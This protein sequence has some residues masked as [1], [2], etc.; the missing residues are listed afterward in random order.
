MPWGICFQK[1]SDMPIDIENDDLETALKKLKARENSFRLLEKLNKLGS[2]E[3]D[4]ITKKSIWSENSYR[5]YDKEP[6]SFEPTLDTFFHHLIPEDRERAKQQLQEILA[7]DEPSTFQGKC[8]LDSQREIDIRVNTQALYDENGQPVKLIGTTQD[9]TEKVKN[10]KLLHEHSKLLKHQ[11]HHDELTQL[12]NRVLFKDRLQQSVLSHKRC[13]NKFA[14]LFIDL[15]HFKDINDSLGHHIGDEVL[16]E[17]SQRLQKSIRENDTLA[18]LGGDEFTIILSNIDS[19]QSA[20]KIAKKIVTIMRKPFAVSELKLH[21]TASIGIAIYPDDSTDENN[22][23]KYADAAMYTSK[24]KGR[25]T[26]TVYKKNMTLSVYKRVILE[27]S[28]RIAIKEED[29]IVYFQAQYLGKSDTLIGSEALIRW[30]H[31]ELD[32]IPPNE[33][34]PLAEDLNLIVNI[35]RIVMKK[36]IK[37]YAQW[38]KMGLNP[39]KLS[40]NLSMKQLNEADFINYLLKIIKK[41]DFDKNLLELEV[42]ETQVMQNPEL[43]IKKLQLISNLGIDIVMDDFGTGYSSLSYLKKLPLK[44]LKI[45]KSFI[46]DIPHD[47]DDMTI[48]KTIIAMG[49]GFNLKLIAEGV[50]TNEQKEFVLESGC[51]AIQ[52]YLYAKPLSAQD[53]E[54][55][56]KK[57]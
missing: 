22:L 12:P 45:D 39:G 51:E 57:L 15:D 3:V 43:S 20:K 42:T 21:M 50:E 26:Y 35:D 37:Q 25:N 38:Y 30:Q 44:K 11:A 28:L 16:K 7:T 31:S 24:E 41:Y 46:Q 27:N 29:F 8:K 56:L 1:K 13:K 14:L 19:I 32:L 23:I 53:M 40:L 55:L 9:I 36:A 54:K 18:R 17:A 48:T 33:F 49:K 2:W 10:D 5:I 6:S 34:I 52:G 47:E 4:L